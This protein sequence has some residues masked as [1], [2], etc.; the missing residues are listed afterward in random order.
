M[1]CDDCQPTLY[2]SLRGV[3]VCPGCGGPSPGGRPCG[4]YGCPGSELAWLVS[5]VPY[6]KAPWRRLMHQWKYGGVA[7][8]GAILQD[9]LAQF[10]AEQ[11][12]V[13]GAFVPVPVAAHPWR[14][15]QRGFNQAE[16]LAAAVGE[17]VGRPSEAPLG[18]RF[19]WRSQVQSGSEAARVANSAGVFYLTKRP[20]LKAVLVDDAVTTGSTLAA[21]AKVLK[22][23]G[24][25]EVGAVTLLSALRRSGRS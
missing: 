4:G 3:F 7:E 18:K 16:A 5:A 6:A 11:T 21:A 20:P 8:A 14:L 1:L 24:A 9:A 19:R 13:L 2:A 25:V 12:T 22:A 10:A 23:G 17:A 15:W